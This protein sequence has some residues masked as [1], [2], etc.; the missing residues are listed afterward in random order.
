MYLQVHTLW[1]SSYP[2]LHARDSEPLDLACMLCV[3]LF[4]IVA[5]CTHGI[6]EIFSQF[7]RNIETLFTN[8]VNILIMD[9]GRRNTQKY[10]FRCPNLME[11][12]KLASFVGD[13]K[14]FRDHFGRLLSILSTDVE[15]GLL[16][17][18]V[19]FYDP[20]YQCFTF[21]DYQLLP[22]MEEH[23]YLLGTSF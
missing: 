18:L 11:L 19:Q 17:T 13:P 5:S 12:R 4:V 15:D 14:D 21:P 22:I 9:I 16:F 10:S 7:S 2:W 23:A 1:F 3:I 6:H 8:I 20:V